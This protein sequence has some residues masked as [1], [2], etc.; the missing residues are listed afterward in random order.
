ME[1]CV[2]IPAK[3][4]EGAISNTIIDIHKKLNNIIPFN[5][6]VINDYSDDKT[7]SI[8]FTISKTITNVSYLNNE[9][10]NGVGNAIKFGLSNWKGDIIVIC[11]A[12]ASDSPNDIL[13]SY[14][15]LICGNYQCV[16]GSRFIKGSSVNNYPFIKLLFNRL[17]NYMVKLIVKKNFNDFTNIFKMY[18]RNAIIQISPIESKGFSIGLEMSLKAFSKEL[19]IGF[20][21][22]SWKQRTTGESKLNLVKNIRLYFS[23]LIRC[24]KHEK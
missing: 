3:N 23:T 16:F 20:I 13:R 2:L 9:Y 8:L 4:E 22:I 21:P 15:T 24:V 6:L 10:E 17:F 5:I 19:E 12:D 11:M 1:L 14:Q 18:R 7:E